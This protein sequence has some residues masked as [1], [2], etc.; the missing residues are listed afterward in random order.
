MSKPTWIGKLW[1]E[2]RPNIVFWIGGFA[3]TALLGLG[4]VLTKGLTSWQQ[5]GIITILAIFLV[6]AVMATIYARRLLKSAPVEPDPVT[7]ENIEEKIN[8]WFR[9]FRLTSQKQPDEPGCHFNYFV[10]IMS[11][12]QQYR[13][14]VSRPIAF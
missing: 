11:Q 7:P 9:N 2:Q 13:I 5:F 6:W 8:E 3:V 14:S 4:A 10:S 12:L 1:E